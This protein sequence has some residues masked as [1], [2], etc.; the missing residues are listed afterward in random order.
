MRP[1]SNLLRALDSLERNTD[2]ITRENLERVFGPMAFEGM[3]TKGFIRPM[4]TTRFTLTEAG[5]R[6]LRDLEADTR[7]PPC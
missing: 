6:C 7:L 5:Q 1:Q 4:R 3:Q 2:G